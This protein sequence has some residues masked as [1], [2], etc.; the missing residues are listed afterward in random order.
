M[1]GRKTSMTSLPS[2]PPAQEAS[3][4]LPAVQVS[5]HTS[6]LVAKVEAYRRGP[7]SKCIAHKRPSTQKQHT[8]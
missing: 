6:Q 3:I 1:W 4:P 2:T 7:H 5:R 8:N